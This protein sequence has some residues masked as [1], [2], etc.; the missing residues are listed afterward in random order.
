MQSI[1]KINYSKIHAGGLPRNSVV[2][3]ANRAKSLLIPIR[4]NV[5][6]VETTALRVRHQALRRRI[7]LMK[8]PEKSSVKIFRMNVNQGEFETSLNEIV[9]QSEDDLL[10]Q[11]NS[12]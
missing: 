1:L 7:I 9:I 2:P 11:V 4:R 10:S 8:Y 6:L 5:R 3:Y 12:S